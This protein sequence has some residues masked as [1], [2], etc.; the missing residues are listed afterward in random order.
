VPHPPMSRT[1]SFKRSD[2]VRSSSAARRAASES[3]EGGGEYLGG[4]APWWVWVARATASHAVAMRSS[5]VLMDH[6]ASS[7]TG[8]RSRREVRNRWRAKAVDLN[9]TSNTWLRVASSE[10][11]AAG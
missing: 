1:N 11:V 5:T 8:I 9:A 7:G 6:H 2:S 4:G 3:A 10:M